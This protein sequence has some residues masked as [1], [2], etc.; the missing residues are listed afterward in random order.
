MQLNAV[1]IERVGD[2][3]NP[4]LQS[5]G[6][7]AGIAFGHRDIIMPQQLLN[8][9]NT[10]AIV[11]QKAGIGVAQVMHPNGA[12]ARAVSSLKKRNMQAGVGLARAGVGEHPAVPGDRQAQSFRPQFHLL[13]NR[14]GFFAQNHCTAAPTFTDGNKKL[15]LLQINAGPF[16]QAQFAL[17]SPV[18]KSNLTN[19][20]KNGCVLRLQALSRLL[21]SVWVKKRCI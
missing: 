3:I 9:I 7:K 12:Q 10:C 13:Q 4:I 15:A 16:G 6:K 17:S 21:I 20:C 18:S 1:K 19:K 11:N 8:L 5:M 2:D 14:Q